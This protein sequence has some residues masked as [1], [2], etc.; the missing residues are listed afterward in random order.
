[1]DRLF[2]TILIN[3]TGFFRD[4][5]TWTFL[6]QEVMPN[7]LADVDKDREIRCGAPAAPVVRRRTRW[8]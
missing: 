4:G 8:R 2:N 3:V 7:L 5:E 6:Q 1:M